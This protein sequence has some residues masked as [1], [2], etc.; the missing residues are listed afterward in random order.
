MPNARATPQAPKR[1]RPIVVRLTEDEHDRIAAAA[2][3]EHRTVS[4]QV[5]HY[6]ARGL[7]NHEAPAPLEPAGGTTHQE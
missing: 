2:L 4:G 5:R 3:R 7:G 1:S 6:V